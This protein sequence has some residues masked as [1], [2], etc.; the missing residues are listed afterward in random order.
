M[1]LD[2]VELVIAVEDV[3]GIAISDA[4]AASMITPA[5]LI[6]HVQDTVGATDDLKSCISLRA[7]HRVRASLM[8]T[9]GVKRSDITLDTPIKALFPRP[10]RAVLWNVF[11]TDSGISA[12]PPLRLGLG[13]LLLPSRVADLVSIAVLDR[14]KQLKEE[15]TWTNEEV[16]Q[17][18]REIIRD[19]LGIKKFN[20]T[21]EF[22]RD[23]GLD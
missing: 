2:S 7:F 11:R 16:R 8:R 23:L 9:V 17:I 1:G 3:F 13:W 15:R 22:V 5:I 19:Q 4:A 20:D 10:D 12:L 6:S 21:D 14:G 18:I